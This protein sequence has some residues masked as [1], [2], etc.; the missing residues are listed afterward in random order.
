MIF[1]WKLSFEKC[2]MESDNYFS[3]SKFEAS[4]KMESAVEG[5]S[6]NYA[7]KQQTVA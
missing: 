4:G 7:N 3:S 5:T 6:K 1:A 2:K